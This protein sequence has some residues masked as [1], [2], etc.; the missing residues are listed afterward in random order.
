MFGLIA[1]VT[2]YVASGSSTGFLSDLGGSST[3]KPYSMGGV[4]E[5]TYTV[6]APSYVK[7]LAKKK[8][9]KDY[10]FSNVNENISGIKVKASHVKLHVKTQPLESGT[11]IIFDASAEN[12]EVEGLGH[13]A[14]KD[15]AEV[16]GYGILNEEMTKLT[17][18]IPW[19][20]IM[21]NM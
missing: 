1:L 20:E 2:I 14:K 21:K 4:D 9:E 10:E 6:D 11:K 17:V 12:L 5:F 19:A 8:T 7:E 13:K 15:S 16:S 3:S 18:H